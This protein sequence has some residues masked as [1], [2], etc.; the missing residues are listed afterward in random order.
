MTVPAIDH[1][2]IG[3]LIRWSR[4]GNVLVGLAGGYDD[5]RDSIL[6]FTDALREVS[7]LVPAVEC[8]RMRGADRS[9]DAERT[10]GE[11]DAYHRGLL[12]ARTA[13]TQVAADLAMSGDV[14]RCSGVARAFEAVEDLVLGHGD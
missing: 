5:D 12:D 11:R 7:I 8:R 10:Q 14:Q 6:L 4:D 1:P 2:L 13:V 9:F 3:E